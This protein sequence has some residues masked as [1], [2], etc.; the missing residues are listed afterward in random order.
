MKRLSTIK[1][2]KTL[3]SMT[4]AMVVSTFY[5]IL[6]VQILNSK[7]SNIFF[8]GKITSNEKVANYKVT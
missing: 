2:H 5:V 1:L 7:D 4:F 8:L 6:K 3:S